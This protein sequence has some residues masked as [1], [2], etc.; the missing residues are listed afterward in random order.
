M[1]ELPTSDRAKLNWDDVPLFLAI[2]RFRSLSQTARALGVTHSTVGRRLKTLEAALGTKLFERTP[3][4]FALTERGEILYREAEGIEARFT[5]I[6]NQFGDQHAGVGGTIRIATMEALGSLYLAPNL[7][8]LYEANPSIRVE[9]VTASAWINLSKREADVMISFPKP[10]GQRLVTEKIGEF[11][12]FLYASS[13]YLARCGMPKRRSDLSAHEF[14]D[15]I[16]ELVVI[17]EVRWLS[18]VMRDQDTVFRSTSLVAQYEA[19]SRGLGIAMLPTFVACKDPKLTPILPAQIKVTRD[20]WL[21][22]HKDL[23]HIPRVRQV[24]EFLRGLIAKDKEFLQGK[25]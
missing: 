7:R 24:L 8:S 10:R 15:Y 3:R 11:S 1:E 14:I 4:G 23:E 16:D 13:D 6:G 2:A 18:D 19:A 25:P 5:E 22:V 20:F 12:L 9:L 17:P 21:S